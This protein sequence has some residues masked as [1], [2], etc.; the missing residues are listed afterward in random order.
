MI[1]PA[2]DIASSMGFDNCFSDNPLCTASTH[3]AET[4]ANSS[5]MLGFPKKAVNGASSDPGATVL[6]IV[7]EAIRA[8]GSRIGVIEIQN[9]GSSSS[10]RDAIFSSSSSDSPGA[11]RIEMSSLRSIK[12]A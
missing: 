6:T 8:T 1:T 9:P 7:F 11:S 5:A 4:A 2:L 10:D 12:M 3:A